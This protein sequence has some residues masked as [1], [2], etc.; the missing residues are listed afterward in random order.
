MLYTVTSDVLYDHVNAA[1]LHCSHPIRRL[2]ARVVGQESPRKAGAVVPTS[3]SAHR[4]GSV[5]LSCDT[6]PL[7]NIYEQHA[8]LQPKAG[9][10]RCTVVGGCARAGTLQPPSDRCFCGRSKNGF[11]S[12]RT[13]PRIVSARPLC[14]LNEPRSHSV[15]FALNPLLSL[16]TFPYSAWHF[17]TSPGIC[18][19]PPVDVLHQTG[20][21]RIHGAFFRSSA[22][23]SQFQSVLHPRTCFTMRLIERRL[24]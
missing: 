6:T 13:S 17:H 16:R 9:R 11:G 18:G 3:N 4:T 21:A 1:D 10:K 23:R 24:P 8:V 7:S 14:L 22:T 19:T 12:C 2:R 20:K 5:I 15:S